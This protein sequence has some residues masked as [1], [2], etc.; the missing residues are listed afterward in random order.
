MDYTKGHVFDNTKEMLDWIAGGCLVYVGENLVKYEKV[1]TSDITY[2]IEKLATGRVRKALR[3]MH[4]TIKPIEWKNTVTV[5]SDTRLIAELPFGHWAT[6]RP[7]KEDS[8]IVKHKWFIQRRITTIIEGFSDT[9]EEAVIECEKAWVN[10]VKEA[11]VN[12]K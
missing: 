2:L 1:S 9:S 12:N 11:L 7:V 8:L 3:G 5:S 10:I 4:I 6:V